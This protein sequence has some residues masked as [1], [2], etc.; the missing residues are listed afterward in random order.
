M[1]S[2]TDRLRT[3]LWGLLGERPFADTEV[4]NEQVTRIRLLML[5]SLGKNGPADF[6][7]LYR[8]IQ[9]A[10]DAEGLWY[11]RSELMRAMTSMHGEASARTILREVTE[12]FRGLVNA[13]LITSSKQPKR[14]MR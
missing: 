8:D 5:D 1:A 14:G 7:S 6:K 9:F 3:S 11:C 4:T 10:R 12:L 2:I 13:N